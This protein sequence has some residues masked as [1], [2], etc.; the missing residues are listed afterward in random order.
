MVGRLLGVVD[1]SAEGV[2][3]SGVTIGSVVDS[4]GG[5]VDSVVGCF[6]FFFLRDFFFL[7]SPV[8]VAVVTW[9]SGL[10]VGGGVGGVSS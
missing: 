9:G 3:D 4:A 1:D 10:G 6:F 5:N 8:G 7:G 2:V